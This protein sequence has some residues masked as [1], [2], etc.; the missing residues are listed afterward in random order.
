MP[1]LPRDEMASPHASGRRFSACIEMSAHG[2]K[3]DVM[4]LT[5]FLRMVM[6][7]LLATCY[8]IFCQAAYGED[9][10]DRAVELHSRGRAATPQP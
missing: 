3:V 6:N 8:P 1:W 9:N 7:G 5:C 2:G 10:D 4:R